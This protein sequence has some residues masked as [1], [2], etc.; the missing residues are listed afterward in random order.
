MLKHCICDNEAPHS[1]FGST[2]VKK[3]VVS[4]ARSIRDDPNSNKGTVQRDFSM[5]PR[6]KGANL[7]DGGFARMERAKAVRTQRRR[8]P[9]IA[10]PVKALA[11]SL[12]TSWSTT[13]RQ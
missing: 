11:R 13:K 6:N 12:P 8:V 9:G 1:H 10:K 2:Y 3:P 7:V 5:P 4:M